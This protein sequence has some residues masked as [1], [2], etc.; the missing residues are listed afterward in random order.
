MERISLHAGNSRYE[1]IAGALDGYFKDVDEPKGK[2]EVQAKPA[3]L[4]ILPNLIPVREENKN[5][6]GINRFEGI[7]ALV[8]FFADK[9]ERIAIV[10]ALPGGDLQRVGK[11]MEFDTL[12]VD[13]INLWDEEAQKTIGVNQ[14]EVFDKDGN[15]SP[16]EISA[17]SEKMQLAVICVPK[18]H[19]RA[20]FTGNVKNQMGL[21]GTKGKMHEGYAFGPITYVLSHYNLMRLQKHLAP[22]QPLYICDAFD[23]MEGNGPYGQPLRE[24]GFG[25]VSKDAV[26]LDSIA[27]LLMNLTSE[28]GYIV[29]PAK[30]AYLFMLAQAAKE[31]KLECATVLDSIDELYAYENLEANISKEEFVTK[32]QKIGNFKAHQQTKPMAEASEAIIEA[33]LK[34]PAAFEHPEEIIQALG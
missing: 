34:N 10:Y 1:C 27:L 21:I 28:D 15:L 13:V 16:L 6:T 31:G 23:G 25:M 5:V 26:A 17:I 20:L 3:L 12:G 19:D 9:Y 11:V 4:A 2:G 14:F 24:L 8:D 22:S 7:K 18:T 33:M 30:V 32:V 29:S